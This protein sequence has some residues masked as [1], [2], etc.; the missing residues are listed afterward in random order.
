L[1]EEFSLP[2][3]FGF[4]PRA[5]FEKGGV[6]HH[7]TDDRS[8]TPVIVAQVFS[9]VLA[10]QHIE[11][12]MNEFAEP[13]ELAEMIIETNGKAN[14]TIKAVQM[15]IAD[16]RYTHIL[17]EGSLRFQVSRITWP[18]HFED[19]TESSAL[20]I[21]DACAWAIRK[22]LSREKDSR[23]FY[24]PLRELFINNI[25]IFLESDDHLDQSALENSEWAVRSA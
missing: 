12:W 16:P 4:M 11:S 3:S 10:T 13:D 19:K 24:E 17:S 8:L 18:V 23:R 25:D 22:R 20:A 21:A 6:H 14:K 1:P 5:W 7:L 2:I 9:F 15:A